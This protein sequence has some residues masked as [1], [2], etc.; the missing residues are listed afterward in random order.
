VRDD[1]EGRGE[2]MK[3]VDTREGRKQLE[4]SFA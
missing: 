4:R 1:I 3:E 2:E